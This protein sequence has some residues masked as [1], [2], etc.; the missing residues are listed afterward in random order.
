M[1]YCFCLWKREPLGQRALPEMLNFG[2]CLPEFCRQSINLDVVTII[3]DFSSRVTHD[4]KKVNE[5]LEVIYA[6]DANKNDP[7]K[8]PQS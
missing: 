5:A 1:L 3:D 4:M 6:S 7:R 2:L 8:S